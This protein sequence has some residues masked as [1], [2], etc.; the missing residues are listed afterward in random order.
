[1]SVD[2][3][4]SHSEGI[5]MTDESNDRPAPKATNRAEVNTTVHLDASTEVRGTVRIA[6]AVLIQLIETT[7]LD[8]SGVV[9]LTTHRRR[10]IEDTGEEPRG[11]SFDDGKVRVTV[12]GDQID[13]DVSITV[14]S[15]TNI[16]RLTD[17][18]REKVGVAAG[19]MLGMTVRTVDVYVDDIIPASE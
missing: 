4:H 2:P 19:R 9:A 12:D 15:G 13:A 17:K 1:M 7:V 8:I 18:I 6:P 3:D 10:K 16:T 5:A 11:K 14:R